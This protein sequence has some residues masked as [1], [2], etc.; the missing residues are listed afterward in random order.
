MTFLPHISRTALLDVA[1]NAARQAG[2]MQMKEFGSDLTVHDF[3]KHDI[4]LE[5]DVLCQDL[6]T[7]HI[8]KAFPDHAILGEEGD[9]I[10]SGEIEWIVDP[11]DGTVNYFYGIPHFCVSIAARCHSS[12]KIIIGVIYDPNQDELWTVTDQQKPLLNNKPIQVSQR[13]HISECII[14]M[15]FSKA[16]ENIENGFARYKRISCEARKTRLMGSAAL[17][18]AYVACGRLDAYVEDQISLWDVAAGNLM[19]ESLGGKVIMTPHSSGKNAYCICAWNGKVN[20]EE[21]AF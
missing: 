10:G 16:P 21:Y 6:I 14:T 11:I 2:E 4:K 18:L 12:Q 15:G 1:I 13:S 9:S 3:K 5:M 19:I 20:I 17:A 8:L 7:Q